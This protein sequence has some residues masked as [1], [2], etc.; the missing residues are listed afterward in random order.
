[1]GGTHVRRVAGALRPRGRDAVEVKGGGTG[2]GVH[3]EEDELCLC[4]A[5][6]LWKAAD[7]KL[8]QATSHVT[9][10]AATGNDERAV[11]V[12]CAL[13]VHCGVRHGTQSVKSVKGC[14][15][16]AW[17]LCCCGGWLGGGGGG[18]RS[19]GG[20]WHQARCQR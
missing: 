18:G 4:D 13:N 5:H 19:R 15:G 17:L 1:M 20:G 14:G 9:L 6:A 12:G 7:V 2:S 8:D 16:C 3:D 11:A 10:A